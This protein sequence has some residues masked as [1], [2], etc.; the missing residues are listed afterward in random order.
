MIAK[1]EEHINTVILSLT[2]GITLL[3]VMGQNDKSSSEDKRCNACCCSN[4]SCV[5]IMCSH[6]PK[7]IKNAIAEYPIDSSSPEY[8]STSVA[9]LFSQ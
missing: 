9:F 4:S 6:I 3:H 1:G 7:K 5:A 8:F 2:K